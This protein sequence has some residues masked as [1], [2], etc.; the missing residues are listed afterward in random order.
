[1][2]DEQPAQRHTP[3]PRPKRETFIGTS[4][5]MPPLLNA[6]EDAAARGESMADVIRHALTCRLVRKAMRGGRT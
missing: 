1:M 5:F 3:G 4:I 6:A 2:R